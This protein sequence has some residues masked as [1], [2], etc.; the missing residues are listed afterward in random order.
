MSEIEIVDAVKP[1]ANMLKNVMTYHAGT[2]QM[3]SV[4]G[5][6]AVMKMA[7]AFEAQEYKKAGMLYGAVLHEH[8]SS[9]V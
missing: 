7:E 3:H 1:A 2:T 5:E 4:D 8:M 9:H 6:M